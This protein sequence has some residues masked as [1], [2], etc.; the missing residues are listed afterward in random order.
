MGM[1]KAAPCRHAGAP[2][3]EVVN[4]AVNAI[5]TI[6][7]DDDFLTRRGLT[8]REFELALPTA[9][10]R[11]RGSA[12]A[13]NS[14]RR[15]FLVSIFGALKVAGVIHS[16]RMPDYGDDTV[17]QLDV[18]SVG[19][20]AIIQKGCP[21]GNHS[22]VKWSRP[23]WANEAYLW[24]L[25]DSLSYQPG[26][27]IAK[28]VNRLRNRF[29]DPGYSDAVD[30][31]IFHNSMCGTSVR[32][33]P[34]KSRSV[35]IGET[36]VPPPCLWVMPDRRGIDEIG[37]GDWNWNGNRE[38]GFPKALLSFFGIVEAEYLNYIGF[39]GFARGARGTRAT[40][41]SRYGPGQTT[42]FRSDAR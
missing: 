26:E 24:W 10:Q 21:D 32:P 8:R 18:P 11:I 4:L 31:V 40:I 37:P 14:D 7:E 2:P 30:G 15:D 3:E 29:F 9:I 41:A 12:A 6:V 23:D 27:H 42:I 13:S 25:C 34:K 19:R 33:C 39:V 20:V 16:F 28:G 17:Y 36:E 5:Q 22:S 35:S 38:L 1:E